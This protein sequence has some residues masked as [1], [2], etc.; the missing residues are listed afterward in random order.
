MSSLQVYSPSYV[1]VSTTEKELTLWHVLDE[2]H[3]PVSTS[4]PAPLS[5]G[6]KLS[7]SISF[8]SRAA[9]AAASTGTLHQW[10]FD[11]R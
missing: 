4:A 11:G 5:A 10:T 9:L 8:D 2:K 7:N 3:T 1:T 6:K